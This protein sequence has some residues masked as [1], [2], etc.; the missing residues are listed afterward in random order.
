MLTKD[1]V[2]GFNGDQLEMVESNHSPDRSTRGLIVYYNIL[3]I[4]GDRMGKNPSSTITLVESSDKGPEYGKLMAESVKNYLET[5]FGIDASRI[6]LEGR[7]KPKIQSEQPG[8][9][10]DLEFLREGDRRV[11]TE[12]SSPNLL[13]EFQTGPD[14]ALKPVEVSTIQEAP[15]DSYI[16]FDIDQD[17][18]TSWWLEIIDE[19]GIVQNYGPYTNEK[20]SIPGKSILGDRP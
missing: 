8:G 6:A 16:S 20:M 3:N 7:T 17:I 19:K 1:Q 9:T 5:V 13:K 15:K 12:S 2:Q 18:F 11:S 10:R 4:L 14:A